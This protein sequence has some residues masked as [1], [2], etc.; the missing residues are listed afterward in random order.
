MSALDVGEWLAS[1]S[2]RFIFEDVV[3]GIHWFR[4]WVHPGAAL[5]EMQK[6]KIQAQWFSR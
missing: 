4:G 1:R 3:S 2:R 5:H 6:K